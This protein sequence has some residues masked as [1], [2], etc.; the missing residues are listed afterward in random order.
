VNFFN[1]KTL[2]YFYLG[3]GDGGIGGG[4]AVVVC[5]VVTFVLPFV[6]PS[7]S[8]IDFGFSAI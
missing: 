6:F 8:G 3:R 1:Y 4:G 5:V 2:F 7:F